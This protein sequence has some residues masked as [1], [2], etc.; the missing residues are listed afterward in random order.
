M[1]VGSKVRGTALTLAGA[2]L[3]VAAMQVGTSRDWG[4]GRPP[5]RAGGSPA[6]Q[7]T[8]TAAWTG[9]RQPKLII[10]YYGGAAHAMPAGRGAPGQHTY[11]TSV[12]YNEAEGYSM[13]VVVDNPD[14]GSFLCRLTVNGVEVPT[15]GL[16]VGYQ[17]RATPGSVTC[18]KHGR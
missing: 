8:F 6:P 12:L 5:L 1:S 4:A 2:A 9:D 17:A 11:S 13:D 16:N 18:V 14:T 7:L 10:W 3:I 15:D